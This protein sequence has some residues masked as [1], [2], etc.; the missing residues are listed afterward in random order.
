[1]HI[2][3]SLFPSVHSGCLYGSIYESCDHGTPKGLVR[4]TER[5]PALPLKVTQAS[6]PL[7]LVP[8]WLCH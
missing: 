2:L 6:T 3:S 7:Q 4:Q 1:M 5:H 8:V